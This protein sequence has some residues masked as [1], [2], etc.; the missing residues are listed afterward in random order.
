MDK[1]FSSNSNIMEALLLMLWMKVIGK[2]VKLLDIFVQLK[3]KK[4]AFIAELGQVVGHSVQGG[5]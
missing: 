1:A 3:H 5:E 2:L 4:E